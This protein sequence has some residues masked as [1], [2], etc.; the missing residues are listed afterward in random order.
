M[1]FRKPTPQN[2]AATEASCRISQLLAKHKE[3]FTDGDLFKVATA[4]TAETVFNG[5]KNKDNIK[6]ALRSV[7][8]GPNIV[9]RRV[10]KMSGDV[11]R[12]VLKDLSHFE[13][14]SLLFDESLDVVDTAQL[15]STKDSTTKEDLLTLLRLKERTRSED[16]YNAFKKYVRDNDDSQTGGNYH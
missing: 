1:L 14:F 8:L 12:Q 4:I 16:I 13:Y 10:E 2:E 9:E 3:P 15:V 6:T 5:F 7:Q 11:N